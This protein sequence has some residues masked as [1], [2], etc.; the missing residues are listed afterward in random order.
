MPACDIE[1]RTTTV[2]MHQ[3]RKTGKFI[4]VMSLDIVFVFQMSPETPATSYGKLNE[5]K[6]NINKRNEK[7]MN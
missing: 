5:K 1:A 2:C 7:G 4:I 6:R 3:L